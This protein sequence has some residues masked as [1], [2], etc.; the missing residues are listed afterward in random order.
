VILGIHQTLRLD[1]S[2]NIYNYFLDFIVVNKVITKV[3][4]ATSFGT[5]QWVFSKEET[6]RCKELVK[7]FDKVS[8][9]DKSD[10]NLCQKYLDFTPDFVLDPTMLLE[11]D[12]YLKLTASKNL[13]KRS[14]DFS[15]ILDETDEI[16]KITEEAC[17]YLKLEHFTNQP[18]N[19]LKGK[20]VT[21]LEDHIYTEL[22]GW[23]QSFNDADFIVTNSF[24][25]I[26][27]S[28]LFNKPF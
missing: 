11:K 6:Q 8:V 20:N 21:Q 4:Y 12:D 14:R 16:A 3:A 24:H 22:E 23:L 28:I 1:Y 27:F 9:R 25:G 2:P 19:R 15:Y 13:P 7:T 18:K 10:I 17:Q 5:N 26:I